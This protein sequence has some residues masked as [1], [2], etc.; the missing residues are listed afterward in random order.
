MR[1]PSRRISNGSSSTQMNSSTSH[2]ALRKNWVVNLA[3]P[4]MGRNGES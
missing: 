3:K 2:G 1:K 4:A